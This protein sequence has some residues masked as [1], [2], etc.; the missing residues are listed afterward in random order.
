MANVAAAPAP[1]GGERR[2]SEVRGI[3]KRSASG[4]IVIP[5]PES[6]PGEEGENRHAKWDERNLQEN[7]EYMAANP[8]QKIDEPPTPF[9]H[10][11]MEKDDDLQE[12]LQREGSLGAGEIEAH[13]MEARLAMVG[14]ALETRVAASLQAAAGLHA[15]EGDAEAPEGEDEEAEGEQEPK[16]TEEEFKAKRRAVYAA[17]GK[18]F[19]ELLRQQAAADYDDDDDDEAAAA[20]PAP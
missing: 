4:R 9:N 16:V 5:E 10:Y 18:S 19:K 6:A 2:G 14:A 3:L 13:Q 20:P 17:E 8:K 1:V 7:A 11:E 15:G 12:G